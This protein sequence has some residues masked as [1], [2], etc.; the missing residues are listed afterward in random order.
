[1]WKKC[2]FFV[3]I[4]NF[5]SFFRTYIKII[6][7]NSN[8]YVCILCLCVSFLKDAYCHIKQLNSYKV[9]NIEF[10]LLE[11]IFI[12]FHHSSFTFSFCFQ[13]QYFTWFLFFFLHKGLTRPRV[14]KT[15]SLTNL[16]SIFLTID[17]YIIDTGSDDKKIWKKFDK[18]N[19]CCSRYSSV[20][21]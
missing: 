2:D 1:M 6:N 15:H 7:S 12:L 18:K 21:N 20:L 8:V 13:I 19:F 3:L 10:H 5:F 17:A 4:N 11:L 16:F 9:I 14:T